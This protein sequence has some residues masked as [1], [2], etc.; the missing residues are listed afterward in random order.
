MAAHELRTPLTTISGYIQLLNQKLSGKS[1]AESRWVNELLLE[2]KRMT[3]LINEFLEINRI[4]TGKLNYS[5]KECSLREVVKRALNSFSFVYP[6]RNIIY[7]DNLGKNYDFVV[8]DTDKLE[9]VFINLLENAAKFSP[10]KTPIRLTF[11]GGL[12]YL[13]VILTDQGVGIAKRE[14]SK[15]GKGIYQKLK[16]SESGMGLGLFLVKNIVELH[17]GT[18]KIRSKLNQGTTVEVKLPKAK[19]QND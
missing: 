16:N 13:K 7:T 3:Q 1:L 12:R 11:Q 15:I 10:A 8:G 4:T 19:I 17:R 2:S 14:L 6:G 18:F 5:L 9:Q